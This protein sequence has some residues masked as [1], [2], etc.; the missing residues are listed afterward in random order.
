MYTL[1]DFRDVVGDKVLADIYRAARGLYVVKVLH[2]NSTY[3][4]G[5]VA[6]MLYTLIPLLNDVG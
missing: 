4:G 6:E 1:D 5:G 2:I 3:Y